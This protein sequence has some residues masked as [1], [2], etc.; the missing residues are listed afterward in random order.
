MSSESATSRSRIARPCA[1]SAARG[2]AIAALM[3]R[4]PFAILVE[5]DQIQ[6]P[7]VHDY[8]VRV[9]IAVNSAR[10]RLRR[11]GTQAVAGIEEPLDARSPARMRL[12]RHRQAIVQAAQL[13]NH[14]VA[15]L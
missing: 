14:G 3:A 11:P 5:V 12:D 4:V 7:T 8:L 2:A 1:A 13:V 9:E 10:L 6:T 15:R